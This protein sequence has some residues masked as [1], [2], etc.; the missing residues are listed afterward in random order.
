M[1]RR[2]S[3]RRT[4]GCAGIVGA[5]PL[6]ATAAPDTDSQ[7]KRLADKWQQLGTGKTG[8]APAEDLHLSTAHGTP[9]STT[10]AERLSK[11]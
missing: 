4:A 5:L 1:K 2:S 11:S 7:G 10:D 6:A 3:L 8:L 9:Y